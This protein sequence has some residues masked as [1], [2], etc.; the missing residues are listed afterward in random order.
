MR[1]RSAQSVGNDQRTVQGFELAS[2]KHCVLVT[3]RRSGH[4][5]RALLVWR[6][7][8]DQ[9]ISYLLGI[10]VR[11][12]LTIERAFEAQERRAAAEPARRGLRPRRACG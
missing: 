8:D 7:R 2:P 12:T 3:Y 11:K 4:F 1:H 9:H 5:K 10:G 6:S